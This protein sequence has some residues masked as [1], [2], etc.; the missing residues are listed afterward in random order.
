[1]RQRRW[2]ELLKDYDCEIIYHPGKGNVVAGALSRKDVPA[3]IR[4][5]ACQ[6]VVTSDVMREIERA[7][8]KALKEENIKKERMV[9]QQDNL[10]YNT[11]GV[12]TRFG[13]VWIPMS[14]ELRTKILD[15]AHKSRY[16]IHPGTNKMYQDLRKEYWWPGMKH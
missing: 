11:L 16:S 14:G 15:E 2:L 13:R 6:L 4:V 3:P 7:Q 5:K 10:E 8:D 12:R 1:M 9:G